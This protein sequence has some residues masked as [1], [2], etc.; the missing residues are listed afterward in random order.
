VVTQQA[1]PIT[2]F[3]R[4]YIYFILLIA[5]YSVWATYLT[6]N[7][8]W[9]VMTEYWPATV[10]MIGGS[11]VAGSTAEGG[12]AVAFPVFTKVLNIHSSDARTFGL[13]IQ[14]FGMGMASVMIFVRR[15]PVLSHVIVWVS[16][17]GVL[18]QIIGTFF[19]I[20]PEPYPRILFTSVAGLFGVAMFISRWVLQWKPR[21]TLRG[22]TR[23]NRNKVRFFLLGIAGGWFAAH[24]GSGID[25]LTFIAL[26]L[27][28]GI[29]EKI[30]TPT[31]VVI[32]A[33]NSMVGFFLRAVVVQ[34]VGVMWDY[35]L[36]A[37]PV[38]IVGA[39]LGAVLAS[40]VKRD[41]IILFL[42]FLITL[43]VVTTIWL[44]PISMQ[45]MAVTSVILCLF[46]LWFRALLRFRSR[47]IALETRTMEMQQ[48]NLPLD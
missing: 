46:A 21:T 9:W 16:L 17:G 23:G 45:E 11:I 13:M 19:I 10:T 39:P 31:T 36:A 29:N 24:T 6:V 38:V 12:A 28:F 47:V 7:E 26:T 30:S 18:G 20:M 40:K 1:G 15:I 37:V 33:V 48:L 2:S 27:A 4:R 25:M 43:E 32:M 8:R 3:L 44:V 41:H 5:I 35:W 42:L 34:D 14:S 22:W